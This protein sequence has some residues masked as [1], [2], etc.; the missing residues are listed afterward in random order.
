MMTY[1]GSKGN[2][3]YYFTGLLTP[4]YGEEVKEVKLSKVV[5]IK[6]REK[7]VVA[8]TFNPRT[9]EAEAG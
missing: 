9:Q 1:K 2:V 3:W 6:L 7:A 8:H 5:S 4:S